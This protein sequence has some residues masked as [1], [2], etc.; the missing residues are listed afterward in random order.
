M[1]VPYDHSKWDED[2]HYEAWRENHEEALAEARD[3]FAPDDEEDQE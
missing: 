1:S 3:Y 2:D